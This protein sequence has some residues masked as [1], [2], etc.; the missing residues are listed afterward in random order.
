MKM[1]IFKKNDKVSINIDGIEFKISPLTFHQKSELQTH[2]VKAVG[3]NMDEAM[4]SVR[5]SLKY[6]VK[7]IK[8][9]H[10]IDEDDVKREYQLEFEEGY[11]TDDC[12]DELL[13]MPFSNKLNS[14]CAAMLQGIP[15][16]ILDADGKPIEGIKIK[17]REASTQGK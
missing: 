16:E 14:V 3:G 11:L 13:N 2:M 10:Y 6:C 9:V 15:E 4:T 5:K 17:K 8:G 1:I 12:L 7:D